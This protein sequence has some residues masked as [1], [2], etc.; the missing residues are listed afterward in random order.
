MA[1]EITYEYSMNMKCSNYINSY[2]PDFPKLDEIC[3]PEDKCMLLNILPT[4]LPLEL[5]VSKVNDN[6]YFKKCAIERWYHLIPINIKEKNMF[7]FNSTELKKEEPLENT[8]IKEY[9]IKND[10]LFTESKNWKEHYLENHM[11][12]YLENL[13]PEDYDPEQV[14]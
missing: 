2:F 14:T 4:N 12:E 5:V 3:S 9:S 1:Y 13:K 11:R 7:I 8:E 10:D 6:I